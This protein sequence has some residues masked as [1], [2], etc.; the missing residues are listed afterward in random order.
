MVVIIQGKVWILTLALEV[1][2]GWSHIL[3]IK[4]PE[5]EQKGKL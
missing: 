3:D 1:P 4:E 2:G 5:K